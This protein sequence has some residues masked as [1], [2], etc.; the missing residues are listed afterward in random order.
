[1]KKQP[2]S[3]PIRCGSTSGPSGVWCREVRVRNAG[4]VFGDRLAKPPELPEQPIAAV[5]EPGVQCARMRHAPE[6]IDEELVVI[7]AQQVDRHVRLEPGAEAGQPPEHARAVGSTVDIAAEHY[8]FRAVP[9]AASVVDQRPEH[10]QHGVELGRAAVHVA[11]GQERST[12]WCCGGGGLP[13]GAKEEHVRSPRR[14]RM[15][16]FFLICRKTVAEAS[17]RGRVAV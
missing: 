7:A 1:M 9:L 6:T 13:V 3:M 12:R 15:I 11:D 2:L 14:R 8:Q 4:R 17:G 5:P 16:W 10:T